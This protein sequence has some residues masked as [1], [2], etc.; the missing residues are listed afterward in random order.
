MQLLRST[1]AASRRLCS[2]PGLALSHCSVNGFHVSTA[3]PETL[4]HEVG[5]LI[6]M[7][8]TVVCYV[9]MFA[10]NLLSDTIVPC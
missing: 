1:L 5:Y 6:L 8:N 3:E 2:T 10:C 9:T 4:F 7:E